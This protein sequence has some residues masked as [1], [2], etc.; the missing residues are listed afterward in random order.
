MTPSACHRLREQTHPK[1][2]SGWSQLA[3]TEKGVMF[4]F[5]SSYLFWPCRVFV[6]A[7][8]LS[9]VVAWG[10]GSLVAVCGLLAEHGLSC[11]V[12]CEIL[13]PQLGIEPASPA[14]GGRFL[15]TGPTLPFFF[16]LSSLVFFFFFFFFFPAHKS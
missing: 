14:L 6:A 11:P 4:F 10:R 9:L 1:W 8:R 2:G 3:D 7:H 5:S 13:A 15:T 12:A 16:S